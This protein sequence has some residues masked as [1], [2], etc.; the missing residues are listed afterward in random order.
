MVIEGHHRYTEEQLASPGTV[1]AQGYWQNERYFADMADSVRQWFTFD[2]HIVDRNSTDVR[3]VQ[4]DN[5]VAVHVRRGDYMLEPWRSAHG[6]LGDG[7]YRKAASYI[8][9]RCPSARFYVFSDDSN[10]NPREVGLTRNVEVVSTKD[11]KED[12]DDLYMMSQCK[13]FIVANSTFSWWG[14]WLGSYDHKMVVAPDQWY[15]AGPEAY[16]SIVP[17]SWMRAPSCWDL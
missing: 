9:E 2:C 17:Q 13:H 8:L 15:L 7:Y 11:N 4:H 1:I 14:A 3:A 5:S 12:V 10:L 6:V 16:S